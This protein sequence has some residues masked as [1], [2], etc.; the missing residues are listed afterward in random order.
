MCHITKMSAIA[1]SNAKAWASCYLMSDYEAQRLDNT[2]TIVSTSV[3]AKVDL[4]L[5]RT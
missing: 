3:D 2:I 4:N 1:N 5:S